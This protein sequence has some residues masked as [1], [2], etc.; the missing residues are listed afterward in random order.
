MLYY[1]G[2]LCILNNN[3]IQYV[4]NPYF[5]YFEDIS[6]IKQLFI[7]SQYKFSLKPHTKIQI[8]NKD[9]TTYFHFKLVEMKKNQYRIYI[10][11]KLYK[12]ILY[13]PNTG[14]IKSIN[15]YKNNKA[16]GIQKYFY[17]NGNIERLV[18]FNEGQRHG[19]F[20][21]WDENGKLIADEEYYDDSRIY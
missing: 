7:S 4:L 1:S 6:K 9:Y 11:F 21:E 14:I 19:T 18:K 16:H 8:I 17:D 3:I 2:T 5:D 10:D 12:K 20:M 13:Y 15:Y